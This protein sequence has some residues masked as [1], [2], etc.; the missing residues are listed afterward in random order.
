MYS[1]GSNFDVV[2]YNRG[3]VMKVKVYKRKTDCS[4]LLESVNRNTS[5]VRVNRSDY[6]DPYPEEDIDVA[7]KI[8]FGAEDILADIHRVI[9]ILDT[10]LF[11]LHY[12]QYFTYGDLAEVDG[13]LYFYFPG[14]AVPAEIKD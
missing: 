11:L 4:Q 3:F 6:N 13:K 2:Y 9:G 5:L 1:C 7:S 14:G 12:Y 8:I 10:E